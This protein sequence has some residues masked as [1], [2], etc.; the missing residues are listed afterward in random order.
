MK[1]VIFVLLI[2]VLCAGSAFA[3]NTFKIAIVD[4]ARALN[5]SDSGKKAKTELEGLVKSK[6]TEIDRRGREI[7]ELRI[8]LE[9]QASV[10]SQDARKSKEDELERMIREYQRL[11]SDS[12]ADIKKKEKELTDDILKDL[13]ALVEKIGEEEGYGLIF[14]DAEGLILHAKKELDLTERIIKQFNESRAKG[15]K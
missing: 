5:E 11:V 13:R 7:E 10:L 1:K 3:D 15:K 9:K 14:E 8:N 2:T 12:Q 4:L 6:Q